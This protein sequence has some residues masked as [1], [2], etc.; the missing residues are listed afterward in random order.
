MD[1]Q[2]VE[3]I[4][5]HAVILDSPTAFHGGLLAQLTTRLYRE[6]RRMDELSPLIIEGLTTEI[7]G[8][9]T[10]FSLK[11]QRPATPQWLEQARELL[12]DQ[13]REPLTLSKV[14]ASVGVHPIHLARVFRRHHH[15]SVGDYILRLRIEFAC[16]KMVSSNTSLAEI[17]LDAG[18]SHQSHFSTTFKR[19]IGMTPAEYRSAFHRR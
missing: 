7:L 3:N 8:E 15:C 2:W 18:F 5:Q 14:A 13:F 10:R 9:A 19:L 1:I 12:H 16:R 11:Q 17:S 4:R 6:F